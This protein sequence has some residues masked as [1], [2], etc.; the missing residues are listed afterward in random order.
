MVR[1]ENLKDFIRY[2]VSNILGMLGISCY[3]L[4]DTFF[5]SKGL[6]AD[7]LTTLNLAIPAFNFIQGCGLMFGIGGAARYSMFK[8]QGDDRLANRIFTNTVILALGAA[9]IF[10][11]VG[12][13]LADSLARLLGANEAVFDM[14]RTYLQILLIFSPAFMMNAVLLSFVRND[15]AP[16]LAMVAMVAGSLS[17]IVM[18]YIF[19]FPFG[20]GILGAVLATGVSPVLSM[21]ILSRHWRK[22]GCGFRLVNMRPDVQLSATTVALGFPSLVTEV[23]AGV[24]MIMF[25]MIILGL[26]GNVGVAAYGVIANL[27][28]VVTAF[29]NGIAQGMQPL[30]SRAYGQS[31]QKSIGQILKYAMV[32]M[33]VL[34]VVLYVII[35]GLADPITSVFNSE[36]NAQLQHIAVVGLRLYFISVLFVGF[37]IVLSMF[38]VAVDRPVPGQIVSVLRGFLII[39]PMTI[40]LAALWGVYG[41]WLAY[42]AAEGVTAL[43]GVWLWWRF[44]R[45]TVKI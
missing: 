42:P 9:L 2:T 15:G 28:L 29:Y 36:G 3:I 44:V 40:V 38:F 24:V 43:V 11:L 34:S 8:S 14:T 41:V 27:S 33:M 6:G 39:V 22:G 19:I 16:Q 21:L 25:N 7:G 31:D 17:N 30:I 37:N 1:N 4:A 32:T 10:A 26:L 20:L 5:V 12:F 18:D 13:F 45:K 23:S 35:G